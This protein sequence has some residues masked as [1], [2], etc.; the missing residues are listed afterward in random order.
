MAGTHAWRTY[1]AD[2]VQLDPPRHITIQTVKSLGLIA[3]ETGFSIE[4]VLF[5]STSFQFWG[6]EQVRSDVPLRDERSHDG[7][8]RG[9]FFSRAQIRAFERRAEELNARHDGDQACFDLRKV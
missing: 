5:D 1:Q 7:G 3:E 4:E 6:S 9:R 2:W 8:N